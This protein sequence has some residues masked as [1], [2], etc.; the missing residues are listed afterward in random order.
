M[1]GAKFED[2]NTGADLDL[3]PS[4]HVF[5]SHS[6]QLFHVGPPSEARYDRTPNSVRSPPLNKHSV[7]FVARN[8]HHYAHIAGYGPNLIGDVPFQKADHL[9][10]EAT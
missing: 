6:V 10:T 2:K 8:G 7:H 4:H 3:I 9:P 5:I 1:F